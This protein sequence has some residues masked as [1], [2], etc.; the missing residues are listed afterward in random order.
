MPWYISLTPT[1]VQTFKNNAEKLRQVTKIHLLLVQMK[2][3]EPEIL[4]WRI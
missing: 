4:L 3:I 2:L 1:T